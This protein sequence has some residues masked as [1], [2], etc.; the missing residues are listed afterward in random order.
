VTT[1]CPLCAADRGESLRRVDYAAIWRELEAQWKVTLPAEVRSRHTEQADT[2]LRRCAGCGLDWF[3]GAVPGDADFYRQLMAQVPYVAGRWEFRLV[4]RRLIDNDRVVDF[5]CGDGEFLRSVAGAVSHRVGVDHNADAINRIVA[6]GIDAR[7]SDFADF[8]AEHEGAFTVASA[9]QI[10]EHV[11]HVDAVLRPAIQC[12]A[13]AGRLFISVPDRERIAEAQLE[14]LDCPPHHM[15]RWSP[16]QLHAVADRLDLTL[17][18]VDRQPPELGHVITRVMTPLDAR[19]LRPPRST[20]RRIA[21]AL[22][23][24]A[25]IGPRRHELLS[26]TGVYARHGLHGHTMLAELARR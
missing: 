5:G 8:A 12:L 22:T 2:E 15:S 17:V 26:R 14:P 11:E 23:H 1:A 13:P 9:F 18:R 25:L 21:R 19:L 16:A 24:R 20:G 3:V 7:V 6:D 4:R 10:V